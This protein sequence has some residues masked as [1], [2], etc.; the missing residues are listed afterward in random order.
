M[1][2]RRVMLAGAVCL[3]ATF[4][5]VGAGRPSFS[6][7]EVVVPGA[8]SATAFGINAGGHI[9]GVYRDV[10][11]TLRGF[12]WRNGEATSIAYPGAI[13]TEARGIGPDG[14]IVGTYRMPGEPTVNVHGFLLDTDGTFSP[15]DYPGHT[16][17]I[18]QR[19]LANGTVL[20]CR[21]DHD[22]MDTMRGIVIS[23][24][25]TSSEIDVF[26]SM[27]NGATPDG[28]LVVGLFTNMMTARTEGYTLDD[29]LFTPFVVPG[30]NATSAWDV[31]ARGEIV[32]VFRDVATNRFHGY[33]RN[34]QQYVSLDV[35][36]AAATR[37]FGINAAGDVVGGFVDSTGRTRA[38][39]ASRTR[40]P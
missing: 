39:F 22:L 14:R 13:L 35:P 10:S 9:V 16:N 11:N 17:T 4:T 12:V 18:P 6:Y 31:N 24:D 34:G 26:A 32:G 38:F 28:R 40:T 20:G 27:H 7:H 19:I 30:S 15:M 3:L 33:V 2:L 23:P 36:G 8:V 21:H 5:T 29:G 37:A 25:G 1:E